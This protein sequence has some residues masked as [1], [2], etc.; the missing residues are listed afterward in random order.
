[1]FCSKQVSDRW[2]SLPPTKSSSHQ[3]VPRLAFFYCLSVPFSRFAFSAFLVVSGW[4][5]SWSRTFLQ[6]FHL[7]HPSGTPASNELEAAK[8]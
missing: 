2:P 7:P 5:H 3:L 6:Y 8:H 4:G 1:M